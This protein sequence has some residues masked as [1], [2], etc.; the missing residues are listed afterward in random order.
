MFKKTHE[1]PYVVIAPV[2]IEEE[3]EDQL[4]LSDTNCIQF[5]PINYRQ[6]ANFDLSSFLEANWFYITH[7]M[8][9]SIKIATQQYTLC[10]KNN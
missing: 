3:V 7:T 5:S 2:H 1:S 10:L 9:L 6:L 4:S 8:L